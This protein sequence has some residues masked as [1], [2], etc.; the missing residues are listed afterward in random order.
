MTPFI[1]PENSLGALP[2]KTAAQ[3]IAASSDVV[4]IVDDKGV[5]RDVAT[6]IA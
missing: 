4:L 1:A 5:I 2:A 6:G 3:L